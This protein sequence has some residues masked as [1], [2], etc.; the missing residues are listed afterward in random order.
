MTDVT[1]EVYGIADIEAALRDG[2]SP[3]FQARLF[4]PALGA[5]AR[6]VRDVARRKDYVFRD[7]RRRLEESED[8]QKGKYR[9]LRESI[10]AARIPARYG[11][12]RFPRGRAGVYS[13]GSGA[14]QAHLVHEGHG[15][16][17]PAPPYPF[18]RRALTDSAG[19][20]GRVIVQSLRKRFPRLAAKI[21]RRGTTFSAQHSYARTVSRRARR[22]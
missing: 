14:R 21:A 7:R 20:Q 17:R 12:Q 1:I 4:G 19:T 9:D 18:I 11:G 8:D 16:P 3:G 10:R 5:A 6:A 13:G 15:G 2:A 22:R